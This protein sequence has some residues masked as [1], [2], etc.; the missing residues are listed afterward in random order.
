M[1]LDASRPRPGHSS[2]LGATWDGT[3]TNFAVWSEHAERVELCL[4]DAV[5]TERRLPL[6]ERSLGIWH[7]YLPGVGPGTRYGFRAHGPW[8]PEMGHRFNAAKLLLDPYARAVEGGLVPDEAVY[9]HVVSLDDT[10]RDDRDSAPYVPRSVVVDPAFDWDG[11]VRPRTR[12]ADTVIY[13]AHVRGFTRRHPKVPGQLQGTYAGLA[14]P[15]AVEHLVDLGVTAVELLPVHAFVSETFLLERGRSNYWGY[16]SLGFFAPHAAYAAADDASGRVRE[17]KGMVRALH[18]AGLEVLLDVV[19][20]HTAEGSERGPTLAFRGLDN[21]AYYRLRGGGRYYADVTGCGNTLD[22]THPQVLQLVLDSLR[23]WVVEMHVDGFRFDLAPALARGDGGFDA[24]AAFLSAVRQDP[25]LRGVKLI[26]EPWDLGEGGYA[27][28][29][30]PA[31]WSEW[32]DRFRDAARD[33][34]RGASAGVREVATR[35]SGSE[36]LYRDR[37]P[38]ASVN[39]VTSHDG[40]TLRDLVSYERKHN[41]ANGEGN[42]DGTDA[43]RS[44]N[45]GVEGDTADP[46]VL[47]CRQRQARNLLVTLLLSTGV[48]MLLGGD[49]MGRTQHGNNNAYC[50]DNELSWLDWEP[51]EQ[52]VRL[53]E[54]TR[55]LLRLRREHPV[56]R[57]RS[58]FEG[59]PLGARGPKDLTWL[60]LEGGELPEAAWF[61][62]ALRTLGL[63]VSGEAIRE[64][65]EEG[66]RLVDDSFLLVLHASPEPVGFRLPPHDGSYEVVL[67]TAEGRHP[68]RPYDPG[69]RILVAGRSCLLLRQ[70]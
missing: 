67:D 14:H 19:Y 13:E 51:G 6:P 49:E 9:G 26:A 8:F 21:A 68:A 38:T 20:N 23:Y 56:W 30:F 48:P 2:P 39:F 70:T 53:L 12:W 37:G 36:D 50:Q 15:A 28:G 4:F 64:R 10:A 69:E 7:G 65:D 43:N 1:T 46:D 58:F 42:R 62:P 44:Q 54:F 5:G 31:P 41:E 33:F 29:R 57:R 16:N 59:R 40:F 25:V 24:A 34:W 17:F 18:Q 60:S 61:D 52:G 11:D 22:T 35:V 3:G 63:L 27:V 32:N 47:A 55:G 66:R 45:C